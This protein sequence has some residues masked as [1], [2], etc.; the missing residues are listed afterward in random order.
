[1]T[2]GTQPKTS[3]QMSRWWEAA[4]LAERQLAADEIAALP[5]AGVWRG[6][7]TT[8]GA[9]A[10]LS[11]FIA[12]QLDMGTDRPLMGS[13]RINDL[14]VS[15][16]MSYESLDKI[17]EAYRPLARAGE[18]VGESIPFA[19]A[20]LAATRMGA[21]GGKYIAPLLEQ[22]RKAPAAF[23][24][25]EAAGVFGAAIGGGM[26]ERV[27]PGNPYAALGFEVT[28]GIFHP[29]AVLGRLYSHARSGIAR[30]YAALTP[31]GREQAA[32]QKL[33]ERIAGREG[34]PAGLL[35]KMGIV[36][37]DLSL[38]GDPAEVLKML[39]EQAAVPGVELRPALKAGNEAIIKL[40]N[41]LKGLVPELAAQLTQDLRRT[42]E[43]F[44]VAYREA[45]QS[46]DPDT[47]RRVAQERARWFE[48]LVEANLRHAEV[49]AVESI[50]TTRPGPTKGA[51]GIE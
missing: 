33:T 29:A 41:Q 27:A 1:M 28:G 13:E 9:P 16:R 48:S 5:F 39:Q 7:A 44:E 23:A 51:A 26:A 11:N 35:E 4:P 2:N 24:T 18:V 22:A 20:P 17:P 36:K 30:A 31:S 21:T 12:Q 32:G 50:K 45:I 25:T 3:L 6:L 14:L 19:V 49:Q 40:E 47:F 46:G 10:D 37:P 8:A 42:T 38:A 43:A 34:G 15:L